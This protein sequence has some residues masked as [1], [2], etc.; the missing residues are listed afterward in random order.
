MWKTLPMEDFGT[1]WIFM[2]MLFFDIAIIIEFD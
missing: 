1:A 2:R